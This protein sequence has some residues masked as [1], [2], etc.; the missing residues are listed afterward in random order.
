MPS[1]WSGDCVFMLRITA[2]L[3]ATPAIFGRY[4]HTCRPVTFDWIGRNGPPVGRPGFMSKVSIWLAPP[5]AHS[6]MQRLFW[7]A[8]SWAMVCE[9]N[10]PP[11]LAT[12]MPPAVASVALRKARRLRWLILVPI[13]NIAAPLALH[14]A[15]DVYCNYFFESFG[16]S[17]RPRKLPN[18][19]EPCAEFSPRT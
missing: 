10:S 15:N 7:R 5:F 3:S 16:P 18:H 9:L 2:S 19:L 12:A 4:S 6:R 8:A 14:F 11:Q 17:H 1:G 13:E